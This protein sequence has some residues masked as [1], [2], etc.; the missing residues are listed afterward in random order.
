MVY[1]FKIHLNQVVTFY[2]RKLNTKCSTFCPQRACVYC[3]DFRL[4]SGRDYIAPA[5]WFIIQ[6]ECVYCGITN[7]I[8]N[9]SSF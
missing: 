6:K 7:E 1:C 5:D 2:T 8:G 9:N 4:N 3:V